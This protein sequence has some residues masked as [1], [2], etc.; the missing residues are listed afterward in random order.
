MDENF[1]AE[2][3]EPVTDTP[4][5]DTTAEPTNVEQVSTQ[6]PQVVEVEPEVTPVN[7]P[8]KDNET[9]RYEY[10]QSEATKA[11][12]AL[13]ALQKKLEPPPQE[14]APPVYPGENADPIELLKYNTQLSNYTL[15]EIQKIQ[16]ATQ[17]TETQ[18]LE[19]EKQQAIKQYTVAK[20]V[21][22]NKSPQK[23]QNIVSFFA[24]SPHLQN[25]KVYDVMYD[26][27]MNFLNNKTTSEVNKKAPPPPIG[28]E[29]VNTTKTIDDVFNE[30]IV[31]NNKYRL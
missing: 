22:V 9:V 6:E 3:F 19:N 31:K 14:N 26:A 21:E 27:A 11:K 7:D 10:W 30:Q 4:V 12:N 2:M 13:E 28:G 15:K 8:V 18:R 25:P 1:N 17:Q 23:S 24:N 29:S 20:L 16:Q 5:A